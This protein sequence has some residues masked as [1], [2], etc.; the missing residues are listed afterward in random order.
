MTSG[1]LRWRG[2]G[3]NVDADEKLTRVTG[4]RKHRPVCGI[5]GSDRGAGN[6]INPE[7]VQPVTDGAVR[8]DL[9]SRG[10]VQ[11]LVMGRMVVGRSGRAVRIVVADVPRPCRPHEGEEDEDAR[12]DS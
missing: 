5:V 4:E 11:P 7:P 3:R 6:R 1:E 10:G 2:A 12:H 9:G 8:R